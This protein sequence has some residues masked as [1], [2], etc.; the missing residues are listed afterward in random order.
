MAGGQLFGFFGVLI[1]LPMAA[2]IK[3]WLHHA[4]ASLVRAPARARRQ[5]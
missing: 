4:R 5:R 1:A 3:V 2:A